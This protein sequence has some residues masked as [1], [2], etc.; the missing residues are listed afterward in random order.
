MSR[1]YLEPILTESPHA[2]DHEGPINFALVSRQ[3]YAL[4]S[5]SRDRSIFVAPQSGSGSLL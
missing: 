3:I 1:G 2:V 4:T 5:L